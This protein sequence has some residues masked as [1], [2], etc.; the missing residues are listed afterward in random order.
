VL[1]ALREK[2]Y[3]DSG[4]IRTWGSS[5]TRRLFET[6]QSKFSGLD[7]AR[8]LEMLALID[9]AVSLAPLAAMRSARL[10]KLKGDR[11]GQWSVT[12]NGPWRICFRYRNGDSYDVEI[13]DYHEGSL[14]SPGRARASRANT[15]ARA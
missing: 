3:A 8:A 4:V 6:G 13:V 7:A 11:S 10:H 15:Q 14:R 12:V 2:Q 1:D 5:A 9:A